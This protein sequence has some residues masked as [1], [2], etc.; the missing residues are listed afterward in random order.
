[1]ERTKTN[2]YGASGHAKVIM[3]IIRS[4]HLEIEKVFDDD[5]SIERFEGLE[6]Y[7]DPAQ[8]LS[9]NI[10]TIIAIGDN[11]ARKKVAMEFEGVVGGF[12]AH[13]SAVISSSVTLKEGTVI[14][15][16]AS[17]NCD[18]SIGRH[19]IINTGAT[20]EHE[21]TLEDF[22]HIS[23]NAAL[24]GNVFVGEGA[25]IGIGA[26]VI[27]GVNIGRWATIGAGAVII[28]DVPEGTVVVGNPGRVIKH[29]DK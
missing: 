21:C 29:K 14:M 8:E 23:P 27:P 10:P 24:A 18:T 6:V 13:P 9:I 3:D 28:E 1:M 16:N 25:H 11:F 15:A 2:I 4:C 5:P 26:V 7:H 22:V 20:V 12:V 17:I 19:C